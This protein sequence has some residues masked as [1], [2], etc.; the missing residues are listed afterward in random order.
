MRQVVEACCH[1]DPAQRATAEQ[2][3]QMPFCNLNH[4]TILAWDGPLRPERVPKT[5]LLL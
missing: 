4:P 1:E 3:M 2:L 5:F